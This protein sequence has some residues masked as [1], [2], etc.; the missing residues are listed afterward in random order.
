MQSAI[1][2][3]NKLKSIDHRGYPAYKELRGQYDFKDYTLSIDHV[4]GD[5]FAAPSRLS[6]WVKG[7]KAGFP[8]DF[9]DFEEDFIKTECL[10]EGWITSGSARV[11]R[12]AFNLFCNGTPS[13][14]AL[15]GDAKVKECR[16]Y[17]VEDLFCCEYAVY[18]WEAVKVRYPEYCFPVD[19]S[20]FGV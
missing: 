16:K 19:L 8:S 10:G 1:E 14:Y 11:V 18:F 6:V 3:R 15:E 9:Y 13:V 4:Q 17:T 2:L 12:M 7:E 5:P 20:E